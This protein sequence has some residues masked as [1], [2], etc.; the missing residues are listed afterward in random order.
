MS[1]GHRQHAGAARARR[2][3]DEN[4]ARVAEVAPADPLSPAERYGELFVAVQSGR[5]FADSKTFVDCVPLREPDAIMA[6]YAARKDAPDFDLARFVEANFEA[7]HPPPSQ[8]VSDPDQGLVAHIDKLWDVLTRH[9]REHRPYSSLLPLPQAYVVPGGRFGELYYWDS[10]FTMLGL[11]ESG[12]H[13]LL[14]AMADNFAWLIDKYG[15]VPNGNRSYYL[16]RSQPPVFALMVEL[17]EVHGVSEAIRYLPRL[18]RE[19]AYWMEGGDGLHPGDTRRHCACMPDGSVLNRYWDE[20]AQPREEEYLEDVTTAAAQSAR[21]AEDVYRDLRAA[22]A[23]GWDFSSRWF[24]DGQ[25]LSATRTTSIVP[26]DLNAFLFAL[27]EQIA[28]L[29]RKHGDDDTA[30]RFQRLCR[31]RGE[32]IERWL[33]DEDAGAYFDYDLLH[34]RARTHRLCAAT[35]APLFTGIAGPKRARRTVDAL[36]DRLLQH[37]GI[38]TT[39]VASQ[40]QWDEPNGWAP[41]QWMAVSGCRRYGFHDLADEIRHRWLGTVGSLY[42]RECKLV[43][44]YVVAPTGDGA[45]GGGGGEYPLQ[46]GFGWTNGV[47][48][49]LLREAPAD[50]AH[51]ARAGRPGL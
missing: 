37:G 8:Y 27:E 41:L 13:D 38:G 5:V 45:V 12:R 20:L 46:D 30:E 1:Q 18:L 15:H 6:E 3:E 47:T 11:A 33:W 36:R 21:P 26:V 24:D 32:A 23:S 19:H 29:S 49:R 25:E 39:L 10:Y 9:P 28:D 34:D 4:A 50:P 2:D 35:A 31:A 44:K 22:A 40:E 14:R 16:S 17:F 51:R 7:T 42:A 43:E 48:R